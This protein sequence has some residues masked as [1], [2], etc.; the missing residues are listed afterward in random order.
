[1]KSYLQSKKTTT[2][3]KKYRLGQNLAEIT[4]KK[5]QFLKKLLDKRFYSI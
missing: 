2:F 1:M 5:L 3:E 4:R